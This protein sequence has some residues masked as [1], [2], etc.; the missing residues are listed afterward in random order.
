MKPVLS[1]LEEKNKK[2]KQ[3]SAICFNHHDGLCACT[4]WIS[5]LDCSNVNAVPLQSKTLERIYGDE[6]GGSKLK[7]CEYRL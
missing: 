4:K 3:E 2:I 6:M 1:L 5:L 7:H